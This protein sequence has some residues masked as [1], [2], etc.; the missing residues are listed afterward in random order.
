MQVLSVK[1]NSNDD[2]VRILAHC[3]E[4]R[5]NFFFDCFHCL[6]HVECDSLGS[7]FFD[8]WFPGYHC[9]HIQSYDRLNACIENDDGFFPL[10]W[11]VNPSC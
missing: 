5:L 11:Y 3:V 8:N 7:A 1:Y 2:V 4:Y 6:I 9:V 10:V